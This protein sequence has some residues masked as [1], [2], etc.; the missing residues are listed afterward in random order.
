MT[1]HLPPALS[2]R[3]AF[4]QAS[5]GAAVGGALAAGCTQ[6]A[7]PGSPDRPPNILFVFSDQHRGMDLG[8]AGNR[9]VRSPTLDRL[10]AEGVR[11]D[12]CYSNTPVCTPTRGTILT[13]L[14]AHQHLATVNDVPLP[15]DQVTIADILRKAGYRT[16]YIGK[17]HLDGVP[18]NRFT[19]PGPRRQGFDDFWAAFN[20]SHAYMNARLFR[21]DPT[22][23]PL[24]GYEPIGQTD[25]ALEFLR[26]PD[27][28]PWCLFLSWG[29]PHAPYH[30]VPDEFKAMYDAA[31]LTLRPNVQAEPPAP[32]KRLGRSDDRA[33][34][35]GYYAHVT[36]IDAQ[37]KR[38][39]DALA[40]TG[41]DRRTIVVYSSDHGDMLGSHG[42]HKKEQPWEEAIRIPLIVRWPE[43]VPAGRTT[44]ALAG[45][46]DFV[47]TLLALAGVEA[48]TALPGTDLSAAVLGASE[49]GADDVLLAVPIV[50]DQ[51]QAQNV[52]EWRGLRTPR[53]TYA[54][55]W[56]GR[57]WMLYDNQAD[58]H[59]LRNLIDAPSH[60]AVRDRL[61]AR[62]RRRLADVGDPCV[63]WQDT[64]RRLGLVDV[65]NRREEVMHRASPRRVE[66]T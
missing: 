23:V 21:D 32:F 3:R 36:A 10:A 33:D 45:T 62:L 17:W 39:L 31:A 46:V 28:R 29:P 59:Q 8:C 64:V 57:G 37:M 42:M 47:P 50:V 20:C 61:E 53:Y 41:D 9:E 55:W 56:D 15:E 2:S 52:R 25:L 1:R 7:R 43:R 35:A 24:K 51:G 48:P 13:G 34:L 58:P 60:K 49:A 38:L 27:P 54:R 66:G 65:W 63:S 4:L 30:Q 40:E 19:P 26:R 11:F 12:R 5:V 22:P 6:A 14:Y 44:A 18:R 16:G